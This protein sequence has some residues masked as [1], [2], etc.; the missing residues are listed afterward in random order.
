MNDRNS[1]FRNMLI[2]RFLLLGLL[3]GSTYLLSMII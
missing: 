1:N 3:I 2:S